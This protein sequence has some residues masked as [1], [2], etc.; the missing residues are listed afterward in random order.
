M[1]NSYEVV[2]RDGIELA[3]DYDGE[4]LDGSPSFSISMGSGFVDGNVKATTHTEIRGLT[5]AD[6][7][8]I[9]NRVKEIIEQIDK[10]P[11]PQDPN[12]WRLNYF[13]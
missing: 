2:R 6:L 4:S 9:L 3:I 7:D 12:D 11:P 1:G 5:R 10:R 13:G 8:D